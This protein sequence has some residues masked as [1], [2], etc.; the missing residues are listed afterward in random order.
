MAATPYDASFFDQ[1][2]VGSITSAN[3]ALSLLFEHYK[4]GSIVDVG[5]GVGS[6]LKCAQDLGVE[7]IL[8]ID[9][10]YVDRS[11]LLIDPVQFR[12]LDL[13]ERI[14]VDR[15]FDLAISI[16]VAEHLSFYR[17]ETFVADLVK[18]SDVVLFSAALPYQGGTE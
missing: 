17:S 1:Q 10:D 13:N 15:R 6:W 11:R 8:G 4:P 14:E 18:L 5:C 16:E 2:V 3:V 7:D 9:G 12:A